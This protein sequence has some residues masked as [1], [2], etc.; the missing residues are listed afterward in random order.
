VNCFDCGKSW[1]PDAAFER[2]YIVPEQDLRFEADIWEGE[3]AGFLANQQK[4]TVLEVARDALFIE[5]PRLSTT[6]RNRIV[7][8]LES[9][10]WRRGPRTANQRPWLRS[11]SP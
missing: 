9:L 11:C 7:A 1:W 2:Q 3:I 4:T 5:T 6:D 10:G 8:V